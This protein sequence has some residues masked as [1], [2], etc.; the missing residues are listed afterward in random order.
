MHCIYLYMFKIVLY[1]AFA[2]SRHPV[3][4]LKIIMVSWKDCGL[5]APNKCIYN[6]SLSLLPVILVLDLLFNLSKP[7]FIHLLNGEIII[8]MFIMKIR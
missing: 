1:S 3:N 7:Q 8:F 4:A 5:L 2:L 6:L